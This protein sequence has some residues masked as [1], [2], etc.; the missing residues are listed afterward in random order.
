MKI[1]HEDMDEDYSDLRLLPGTEVQVDN[2]PTDG[3]RRFLVYREGKGEECYY[4][5]LEGIS[6]MLG[7]TAKEEE[8]REGAVLRAGAGL[9]DLTLR[10]MALELAQLLQLVKVDEEVARLAHRLCRAVL[11]GGSCPADRGTR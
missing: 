3:V 11:S 5:D 1:W 9:P 8:L 2:E 6:H 10:D 4:A 7:R